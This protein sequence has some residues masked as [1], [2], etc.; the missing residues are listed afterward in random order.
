M[1]TK[2]VLLV[3]VFLLSVPFLY[4]SEKN[5]TVSKKVK[6]E[7][8]AKLTPYHWNV[9]KFNPTPMLIWQ[10]VRNITITYE[11][12]ITKDMSLSLQVGYLLFPR[13]LTDTV[14]NLIS[15][16]GGS[17]YGVNLAL[18]YKY[19]PFSRNRRPAPDGLYIGTYVS[20]YGFNFNN[21][22]DI[23][24]TTVD[25]KGEL[26][27]KLNIVNLGVSLGYQFIFWKRLT[28]DL[29]LFGPSVSCYNGDLAVTGSLDPDQIRNIDQEVVDKLLQRFPFLGTIFSKGGLQFTGTRTSWSVGFR[30]SIQLGVHF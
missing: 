9:I 27:G 14:A 16:S 13:I 5:D 23:L 8:P 20:Y 12:L 19:Y 10:D 28:L 29:L 6:K 22:F 1:R 3:S 26:K 7:K 15:F 18:D 30:Y 24:H 11:R 25:Q 2:I 4:A 21:T 17:K